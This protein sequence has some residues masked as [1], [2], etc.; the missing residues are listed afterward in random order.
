MVSD[1]LLKFVFR[2]DLEDVTFAVLLSES[3]FDSSVDS[4]LLFELK[5]NGR[6]HDLAKVSREAS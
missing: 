6:D 5:R 2:L 4:L 1:L 3:D